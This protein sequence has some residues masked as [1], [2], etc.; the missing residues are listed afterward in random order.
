VPLLAGDAL[1]P[2][3]VAIESRGLVALVQGGFKILRRKRYD[4][5]ELY[6]LAADPEEKVNLFREDDATSAQHLGAM[7]KFFDDVARR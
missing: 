1:P 2:Q 4:T 3:A 7:D 6:D 5:I